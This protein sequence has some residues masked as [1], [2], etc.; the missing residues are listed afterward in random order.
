M[1]IRCQ[2]VVVI[3]AGEATNV[4]ENIMIVC[5][6]PFIGQSSWGTI[7]NRSD[8]VEKILENFFLPRWR[9]WSTPQTHQ[10]DGQMNG[11]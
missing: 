8:E 6:N 1:L 9:I 5:S 10:H 2:L 7:E 3:N 11:T 4:L